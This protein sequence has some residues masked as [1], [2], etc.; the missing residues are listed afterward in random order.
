MNFGI[1]VF[2]DVLKINKSVIKREV[3]FVFAGSPCQSFS[4]AGYQDGLD[5]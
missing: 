3:T 4:Q 2:D 5:D 1:D